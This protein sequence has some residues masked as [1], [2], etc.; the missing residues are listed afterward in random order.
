MK[1]ILFFLPAILLLGTACT[2]SQ[3][4]MQQSFKD[5]PAA[6]ATETLKQSI[7]SISDGPKKGW[8]TYTNSAYNFSFSFPA[9]FQFKEHPA[10]Q[11]KDENEIGGSPE[12]YGQTFNV[13]T[14]E[15]N[16]GP[17]VSFNL[18]MN[19]AGGCSET[20]TIVTEQAMRIGG[21][22]ITKYVTTDEKIDPSVVCFDYAGFELGRN[23]F[24]MVGQAP[25]NDKKIEFIFDSIA[26]SFRFTSTT[27]PVPL[28]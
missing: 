9:D 8:K 5:Q 24:K 2:R 26:Q 16:K 10:Y 11:L 21:Q 7:Y 3:P 12:R 28:K 18:A 25:L 17:K 19:L 4:V 13:V 27:N 14:I 22:A 15:L 6:V 1:K 20:A 23:L